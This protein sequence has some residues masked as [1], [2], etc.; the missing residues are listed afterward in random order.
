M[1]F[2]LL[3]AVTS[4]VEVEVAGKVVAPVR[5]GADDPDVGIVVAHFGLTCGKGSVEQFVPALIFKISPGA[6]ADSDPTCRGHGFSRLEGVL[7]VLSHII[8]EFF[9]PT[10]MVV[11][12]SERT[13]T[14]VSSK[15]EI[16]PG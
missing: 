5:P 12:D 11:I 14:M 6:V 9:E 8:E 2:S 16:S 13:A 7:I 15:V 4:F 10:G 1:S 3:D